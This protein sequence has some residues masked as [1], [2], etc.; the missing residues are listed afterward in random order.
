[1][2]SFD[3]RSLKDHREN[4]QLAEIAALLHDMGKCADEYIIHQGADVPHGHQYKYKVAQSSRIPQS[5]TDVVLLGEQASV[6]K[7]IEHGMPRIISDVSQPWILRVLGRCH[8]AAHVE[9]ELAD[10]E[11]STK[12]KCQSTYLSSAFGTESGPIAGLTKR[13]QSIPFGLLSDRVKVFAA[14]ETA[15]SAALG[16]TRR[17]V[18]EVTLADWS[19]AVASLYKSSL[20]GALLGKKPDPDDLR[21]RLL[22]VNFDVLDM[23][24]HAIKV[25][26]LLAYT[27]AVGDAC[28][29]VKKLLE[30]D[31][32][33][34]NEAYRDTTG[35]YFTFP[36]LDLA[37]DLQH[38]ICR[39]VEEVEPEMAPHIQV[40]CGIGASASEQL[41]RLL[42]DQRSEARKRL[43]VPVDRDNFSTCWNAL[44]EN[45]PDGAWEV[46]PVCRLRPKRE[47]EE[48]CEHCNNRRKSRLETWKNIKPEETI[49][50]DELADENGRIALFVGKFGL[51]DW[52]SGDLVQTMLVKYDPTNKAFVPKNPSP[53]RLRRVW[54]TCQHFWEETISAIFSDHLPDRIRWELLRSQPA[55]VVELPEG[56]VC[57]GKLNGQPISVLQI[58][59][60][61]LTV[62]YI[63]PKAPPCSGTLRVSWEGRRQKEPVELDIAG[64]READGDLERFQKY[65]PTLTLLASPDRFM[66]LVPA[67]D[68]VELAEKIRDA[69]TLEFGKVQNRLPIFLGLIFF[70]RKVPLFA[71][72]DT[73]RRML[74]QVELGEETWHV[75][76]VHGDCVSFK[77]GHSWCVPQKMGDET[78]F[79]HWYPYFFVEGDAPVC[80]YRF[81]LANVQTSEVVKQKYKARWLLHVSELSDHTNVIVNPSRF[82]FLFLENSAQRFEFC[83]K[84]DV[85]YLDELSRLVAMWKGIRGTPQMTDTKLRGVASL[86]QEKKGWK[87]ESPEFRHLAETTL[88]AAGL[89]N[90]PKGVATPDD[91]TSRRFERCLDL[92]LH[93]LKQRVKE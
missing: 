89:W 79:D 84:R 25:A 23:Y 53:A 43:A 5:T 92:Y 47:D 66:A 2:S 31:Y 75:N 17:P 36:D 71:V 38:E 63:P 10:V 24:S 44:W 83:A 48:V 15:F 93:I 12:Q 81:R 52:L 30:Q 34:G 13:L 35:I 62:S 32:P 9:K 58:G 16:D 59:N 60:Q 90:I 14:A 87:Y 20:A 46:C 61:L 88:K 77:N 72:M 70:P 74:D 45:L 11:T 8:A 86:L 22:R 68:A 85:L 6:K 33:L 78:T 57:D 76:A 3:W 27:K 69:Y 50:L 55:G 41:K 19:S 64:A 80:Q 42:A 28:A 7:L 65:R 73:A 37:A 54:E 51:D 91:V 49:W 56:K 21:W 82:S 67:S 26:D 40:G 29:R 1:M 18:N 4:I 39:V